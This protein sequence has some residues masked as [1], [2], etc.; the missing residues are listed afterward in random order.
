VKIEN[1]AFLIPIYT[2]HYPF[3][4]N[5]INKLEVNDIQIDIHL[6]FSNIEDHNNFSM[7]NKINSIRR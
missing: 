5:L 3:I 7:K 6:V 4:Y 1:V 2:P